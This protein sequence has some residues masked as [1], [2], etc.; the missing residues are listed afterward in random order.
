MGRNWVWLYYTPV[1]WEKR[2]ATHLLPVVV[3]CFNEGCLTGFGTEEKTEI[4]TH[5]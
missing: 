4:T 1:S 3:D 2:R 5:R